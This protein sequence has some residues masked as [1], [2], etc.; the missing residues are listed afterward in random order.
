LLLYQGILR[1]LLSQTD[2]AG[3]SFEQ[4]QLGLADPVSFYLSRGQL[5]LRFGQ[6]AAAEADARAILKLD[7]NSA[8]GWLLLGRALEWQNQ[9]RAALAAYQTAANLAFAS[10][11]AE[12]IVLARTALARLATHPELQWTD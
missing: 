11:E 8:K 7:E 6:A 1:Q 9:V 2:G 5:W 3:Q 4:A 12:V 10:G